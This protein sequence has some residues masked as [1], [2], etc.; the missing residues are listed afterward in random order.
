MT[1][2][3]AAPLAPFADSLPVPK[4]LVA[5][6]QDGRLSVPIRAGAHRFHRDLPE[7]VIWGYDGT[8]PGPT[9]EAEQ[10][11]PVTVQWRNELDGALPVVVTTAPTATDA[12][13]VPVQC[14]PG[15]SGGTPD[16]HAAALAGHTVVH[17]HGGL[18]PAPYD[19]WAENLFAP[20]QD[21]VFHY[22][23]GQRAALHWYHDHVMGVTRFGVYAGL[24]GLWIIRDR[25]E[26]ELGLPEGPP[27]EVPLLIQDRN[28]GLDDS[29]RLTGQLVH[30]TDP[31]VME[32]FAPFTVVNGKVWPLLEVQPATYRFRVLNGSNARTYRLVLLRDGEPELGRIT[33]IGTD[34][35][36]LR[37]PVRVPQDGL[38]LASAERADLLVDFSGLEPGSELTLVNT[39]AAPFSGAAFPAADARNAADPGRML[40]YPHVMG[41]RVVPGPVTRQ[42]IPGTLATDYRPP[43]PGA[44]AGAPRRAIALVERELD[45]EP[46]MLTMRELV[47]AGDDHAGPVVTVTDG[48]QITRYR[49]A[50]AHFEDATTFFPVLG[51]YEVWQL[52]NLTGDTHPIHVHLDPFQ[53]LSRRPI[54]YQIPDHGIEDRAITAAVTLERDPDD[55]LGHAID[56]NECGL[57]DTVRVNP[58]EIAEIAV[59]FT[60]YSGRYMYHCHILE[61][62]DRDMMRPFVTMPAELM[63]FMA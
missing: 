14:V 51:R 25:R 49:A 47:I 3:L 39:A 5:A 45:G 37:T 57:K 42:T 34:H 41:F 12:S 8:V 59:R 6:R 19:G 10:G 28:F 36:L 16:Q 11:Q 38:V 62:E 29:G 55:K 26:R 31:E 63:P 60:T 2:T 7:S 9:I 17:L 48:E 1:P 23:M 21:A 30:K 56:D 50:A 24:A 27:F 35:G 53:I 22:P 13:G 58:S 18:V 61:H 43:T 44:L 54:R 52:I 4:R 15:L 32:A 20:G 46:S 33:Q 40:P